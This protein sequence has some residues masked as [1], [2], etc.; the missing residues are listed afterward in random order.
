MQDVLYY[1]FWA[2]LFFVMMRFGC[3]AHIMGHGH[4]K[5]ASASDHPGA[6][7]DGRGSVPA[8]LPD[9]ATDRV[10]GMTVKT[11]TAKTS[12]YWAA[13][14]ISARRRAGRSSRRRPK[15]T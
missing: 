7:P 1:V 9:Q 15:P 5:G 12:A 8:V 6:S 11:S 3:G 2:A 13:F 14:I 4:H 10:C